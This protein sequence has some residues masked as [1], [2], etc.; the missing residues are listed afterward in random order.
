MSAIGS[1]DLR[2]GAVDAPGGAGDAGGAA[3]AGGA[4]PAPSPAVVRG[5]P[6]VSAASGDLA[7]QMRLLDRLGAAATPAVVAPTGPDRPHGNAA[8]RQW[9]LDQVGKIDG[10]DRAWQTQGLSAE[11]RAHKAYDIRH[12]ARLAARSMMDDRIGEH[13]LQLRDL[14]EYGHLDGPT[15]DQLVSGAE[16]KGLTPDQAYESIVH[17]AETTNATV[18]AHFGLSGGA[19]S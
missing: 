5:G 14:F 2:P 7:Q 4:T 13:L 16:K 12:E 1:G 6:G 8:V 10:L 15:F 3:A 9:Y 19:P 11:D 18:N 17:G